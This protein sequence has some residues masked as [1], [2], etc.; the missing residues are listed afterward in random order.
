ME[1]FGTERKGRV[2]LGLFYLAVSEKHRRANFLVKK[3][4]KLP[5]PQQFLIEIIEN[6]N[7]IIHYFYLIPNYWNRQELYHYFSRL[8]QDNYVVHVTHYEANET[9]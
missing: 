3:G 8:A 7:V 6:D 4:E 5:I 2:S 9:T 1:P